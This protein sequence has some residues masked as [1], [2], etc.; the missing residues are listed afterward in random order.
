MHLDQVERVQTAVLQAGL[1]AAAQRRWRI[2]GIGVR[3]D[4]TPAF[5]GE[6]D[7]IAVARFDAAHNASDRGLARALAGTRI[8]FFA[9][10]LP[11]TIAV[12]GPGARLG[13]R[14]NDH[15]AAVTRKDAERCGHAAASSA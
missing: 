4:E 15:G 6:E 5:R 3:A 9:A 11:A 12:R 2:P 14:R 10:K 13:R 8:R 1:D 7:A